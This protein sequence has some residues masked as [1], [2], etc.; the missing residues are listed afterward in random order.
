MIATTLTVFFRYLQFSRGPE[1]DR[2]LEIDFV[3]N[4]QQ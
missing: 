3:S 1:W 2:C 4:P